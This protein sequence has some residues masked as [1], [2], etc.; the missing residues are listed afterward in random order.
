MQGL[1]PDV[2]ASDQR[3]VELMRDVQRLVAERRDAD[4]LRILAE[5][6]ALRPHHPLVLMERARRLALAGDATAARAILERA[7]AAAPENV[8]AWLNLAGVLR[9]LGERKA[10]LEAIER[11]LTL[12]PTHLVA[13]LQKGA[14]L[15][16][17]GKPRA[18]AAI[19]VNALQ[20]LAAGTRLPAPIEAHVAHA[21]RRVAEN[22]EIV[23]QLLQSRLADLRAAGTAGDRRRF[24]RCM[25]RM[26]GRARI[27]TPEP[28][29][30]LFPFLAHYEFF[31]RE[32]F[33]WL[34]QLEAATESIRAEL[35]GVLEADQ[36]GMEPYIAY[37]E[38]LPLN[39]WRELNHSRRW[40]AYFLWKDGHP[41]E[42]HIARC[43][44]TVEALRATPQV[45][46]AGRGPTAFFSMLE[47]R[48][49]I[50]AHTGS[51]NTRLT[52]HLPLIVP[53]GCRFR[54]GS[55]TREWRT[56]VAWVFDDTIEHEAWNDADL[57]RAILIFDIW[58]PQLT[59]LER[60][61]VR[62][63][64]EVLAEYNDIE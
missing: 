11:A 22:A 25:D 60:D 53:E 12:A 7:A 21:R 6:E 5:A 47:P 40:S 44:R 37:R 43:P 9:S 41:L 42:E 16:L 50:P 56:G 10:E 55:E 27:Y 64:T 28:T 59:Q 3:V 52:V 30:M 20:T 14:L 18:A 38:G 24:E 23:A 1:S 19:Y 39:Q 26:L 31:A 49:H 57:P 33:S 35:L 63:A 15:D 29:Q 54:V 36:P 4:A 46:I 51:T 62:G 34:G 48:T 58:N 45:D 8:T 13:L 32:E 61:L 2:G 17:M